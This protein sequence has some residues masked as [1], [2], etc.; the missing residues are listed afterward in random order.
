MDMAW[1]GPSYRVAF[2]YMGINICARRTG[3]ARYLLNNGAWW[4][5]FV[6]Y[7]AELLVQAGGAKCACAQETTASMCSED[8]WQGSAAQRVTLFVPTI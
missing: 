6:G 3:R 8:P 1:Y 2:P 5:L 4:L 7:S